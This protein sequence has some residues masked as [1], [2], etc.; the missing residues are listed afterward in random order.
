MEAKLAKK[1]EDIPKEMDRTYSKVLQN[2]L[3]RKTGRSL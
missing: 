1:N 3:E 2:M